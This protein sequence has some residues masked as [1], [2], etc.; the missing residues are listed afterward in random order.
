M[1]SLM[2]FLVLLSVTNAGY[3]HLDYKVLNL[4]EKS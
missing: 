2:V 1:L 4:Q 3:G